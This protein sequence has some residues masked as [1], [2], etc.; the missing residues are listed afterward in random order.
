VQRKADGHQRFPALKAAVVQPAFPGFWS[1]V[2]GTDVFFVREDLSIAIVGDVLDLTTG[3]SLTEPLRAQALARLPPVDVHALPFQDAIPFGQG[4]RRLIVFA[5]P[6]CPACR[7]LE[8]TLA[9][10]TD[11]RVDLFPLPLA[12]HPQAAAVATAIWCQPDRAQAWQAYQ[13]LPDDP[14]A[15]HRLWQAAHGGEA[16]P[17]CAT[18]FARN[19]ALAQRLG[20]TSTPTLIFE[21]GSRQVGAL[22]LATLQAAL[23][24]A[25]TRAAAATRSP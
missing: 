10:L 9:Q 16:A 6:D 22:P 15:R 18:P 17:T 4:T 19:L 5:D 8:T 2:H 7:Q 24:Q 21:D 11:V 13:Q 12:I 20:I 23:T 1:I 3:R 14:A 25:H